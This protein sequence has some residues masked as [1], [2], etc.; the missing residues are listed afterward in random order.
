[1]LFGWL[2]MAA[3]MA[4]GQSAP[5]IT[6][7]PTNLTVLAGSNATFSAGVSGTGPFEY[8]WQF[9]GAS[10]LLNGIITTVAGG[11]PGGGTDGL[12]DGASATNATLSYPYGVAA[13]AFGN[14]FIAD[15][16][17]DRVRKVDANGIITTVVSNLGAYA[18]AFDLTGDLLISD[19]GTRVW[20]LDTNGDL[21]VVAGNGTQSYSG[22]GGAAT[23]A[24]L[25]TPEG[26]AVDAAGNMR[27]EGIANGRDI[28]GS[29]PL[30]T[31]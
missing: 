21:A 30:V 10:L 15:T 14:V 20:A 11:G 9:D 4:R 16:D 17:D 29:H 31:E 28:G 26:L 12:G 18:L 2:L 1:M 19:N 27:R 13:D 23:N 5:V 7:Q 24:G 3:V 22:D 25:I 8:Q 6:Q